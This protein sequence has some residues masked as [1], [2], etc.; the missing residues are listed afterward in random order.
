MLLLG[1]LGSHHT[2]IPSSIFRGYAIADPVAPFI[3][4]NDKDAKVA[5]AFTTIHELAHVWLGATGLSDGT[6]NAQLESY[7]NRVASEVLLP[8]FELKELRFLR[9]ASLDESVRE[10]ARFAN[11]CKVSRAMV[12]YKLH[13]AN[14]VGSARWRELDE[15]YRNE[16]SATQ[17]QQATASKSDG[18]PSYYILKRHRLGPRPFGTC[19]ELT[20]GRFYYL[21]ESGPDPWSQTSQRRSVGLCSWNAGWTVSAISSGCEHTYNG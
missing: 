11:K 3:V 2:D 18:G 9:N 14:I 19:Q 6:N 4:V 8:D 17:A 7:C 10:I 1:N 5:W 12:A 20:L 15:H 13:Y 16:W 21:H